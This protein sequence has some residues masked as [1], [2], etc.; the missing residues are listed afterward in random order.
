MKNFKDYTH[1]FLILLIVAVLPLSLLFGQNYVVN[2]VHDGGNPGGI[3]T[4]SDA[5]TTGW[6][7]ITTGSQSSNFW[8]DPVAL[9]F[10]FSFYGTAVDYFMVSQ[11]GLLTFDTTATLLP[12]ENENLPSS[13]VPDLTVAATWDA[14]TDSP[15]TGSNDVVYYKTFGTAPDRQF[16]VRWHSFEIGSPSFSYA[17]FSVVLDEATGRIFVVDMYNPAGTSGMTVGLQENSSNAVQ[18]GSSS[19]QREENSASNP[20]NDYWEFFQPAG[21][22][23]GT[24][25]IILSDG[26]FYHPGES[27]TIQ[28]VI[29]NFGLNPASNFPVSYM[30]DDGSSSSINY[31]GTLTSG[32]MDTVSF[33]AAWT[34]SAG[35]TTFTI[36]AYTDL[37]GDGNPFNDTST[38]SV[39]IYQLYSLIY[40]QDFEDYGTIAAINWFGADNQDFGIFTPGT[41]TDGGWISDDFGNDPL[42]SSS[43]RFY[44]SGSTDA[45]WLISPALDMTTGG[46]NP[47]VTFDIAVT[48]LTGTAAEVIPPGDTLFVVAS[49]DGQ[50]WLRSNVLAMYTDQNNIPPTG[51]PV[52]IDLSSYASETEFYIGFFA[53][54]GG[55][56]GTAN[57]YIDNFFVGVPPDQDAGPVALASPDPGLCYGSSETLTATVQNFAASTLDLSVHP[58]TVKANIT[59][60][61]TQNFSTTVSSG[62]I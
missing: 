51:M 46:A 42:L 7:A 38:V 47:A 23:V 49:T 1:L 8:S 62:T 4:D 18:Y 3:N 25:D 31:S 17:Y 2:F 55:T 37:S 26:P 60:A 10:S 14:F 16:W 11:N 34:P 44:F 27:I 22:D 59:G 28:A 56:T 48:P 33:P 30:V 61:S 12:D 32:E 13:N 39:D 43:A 9:P 58:L 40:E 41:T 21:D 24:V 45:D 35:D 53:K 54:E 5:S 15:P 36:T 19:L 6:T 50:T 29:S 52:A 57:V 20:D